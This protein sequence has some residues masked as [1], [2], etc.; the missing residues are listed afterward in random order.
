MGTVSPLQSRRRGCCET[1]LLPHHGD[2][3]A[4]MQASRGEGCR[5]C[6]LPSLGDSSLA[7]LIT[8]PGQ[9]LS[10]Q[11]GSGGLRGEH[12][13]VHQ[14]VGGGVG[15]GE[16]GNKTII[17]LGLKSWGDPGGG[18]WYPSVLGIRYLLPSMKQ[19]PS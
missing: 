13:S 4:H 5:G 6:L 14:N 11:L 8:I 12:C 7:Q 3:G 9:L 2:A 10:S 18:I 19:G 16:G 17:R 15:G 1:C